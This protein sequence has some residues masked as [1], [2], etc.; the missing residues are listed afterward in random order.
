MPLPFAGDCGA[1]P[2]PGSRREGAHQGEHQ[3]TRIALCCRK[4]EGSL[5][6]ELLCAQGIKAHN[7]PFLLHPLLQGRPWPMAKAFLALVSQFRHSLPLCDKANPNIVKLLLLNGG[8]ATLNLGTLIWCQTQVREFL[9]A[10]R[11]CIIFL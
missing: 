7:H 5:A 10:G 1:P 11:E 9:P 8:D 6:R 3:L 2:L 4:S